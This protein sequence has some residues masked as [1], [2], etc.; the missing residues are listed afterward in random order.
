MSHK[1]K[2]TPRQSPA[3]RGPRVVRP[4]AGIKSVGTHI[5]RKTINDPKNGQGVGRGSAAP[6]GARAPGAL[7]VSL[8]DEASS[9]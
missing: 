7:G 3:Q 9:W 4:H 2:P 1:T 8:S 6:E 5:S